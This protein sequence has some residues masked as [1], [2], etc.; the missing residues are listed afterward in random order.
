MTPIALEK[1]LAIVSCL[2]DFFEQQVARTPE[3]VAVIYEGRQ[4]SY[5][6]LNGRANQLARYLQGHGVGPEVLV[7]MYVERS[8]EMAVGLLGILKA[9]GAYVPLDPG[10]PSERLAFMLKDS[11]AP[12]LLTQWHL[13]AQ[14][15]AY[16]GRVVALDADWEAIARHSQQ[17]PDSGV[18]PEAL[19]YV[20]YT[21]GS[22]GLPKGVAIEH[23]SA[24]N[25]L[26]SMQREPGI[27]TRDRMLAV[28]TLSFDIAGLELYLPLA[29]GACVEVVSRE[30]AADPVRLR[31]R[32]EDS[33]ATVMQATPASWRMLVEAGWERAPALKVLC[34]GEALGHELAKALLARAREVWNL[35]GP[36]ETTIWSTAYKVE[37]EPGTGSAAPLGRPIA[38]TQLYVLDEAMQPVPAGI[39][40][41]LYIGGAGLAR[42]YVNRTELTAERFVP[43][44]FGSEPGGRLYRTGDL[45]RYRP[46]GTLEFLG[47]FDQQVKLR[48]FRV[49]LGE[50]EAVLRQHPLVGE[51]VVLAREDIPGDKRLVGYVAVDPYHPPTVSQLRRHLAA[52]LPDY[53][54][55][56]TFVLLDK[57]PLTPNGKV[58]RRALSAPAPSRPELEQAYV[59]PRTPLE[60]LLAH[61]W[62]EVLHLDGVGIHDNFFDLGGDSIKGAAFINKLQQRLEEPIF[63]VALF[64]APTVADF[65]TFLTTSYGEAVSRLLGPEAHTRNVPPQGAAAPV[66]ARGV[67][68]G[69]VEQ[70]RQL[71]VPLEPRTQ[72][73]EE[74][75]P[76][77]PRAIFILA[78]PRSGTTLLRVM[79]AGHPQLFAAAELQLLGFNTL[80]ERRAAFSGKYSLWLEG[81]IRA[82]MQIHG[83]DA[84]Q[85]K[86]I[87]A[88][89]EDQDITTKQFYRV[90]QGWIAPQTLVDKSPSYALDLA[91]LM[92]AESDFVE[93]LYIHL[94]RHPYS[95]V[96]SFERSRLE[97]VFFVPEHPFS[98]QE[99]GELVWLVSHQNIVEFLDGVP[100]ERQYRMHFE[101]LTRQPQAVMEQMCRQLG[102]EYHPDLIEP[103][104]DKEKKMTDGIYAAS[105]PMGDTKFNEYQGIDSKIAESWKEVVLDNFLG[106]VTWEWAERLGYERVGHEAYLTTLGDR[107]EGIL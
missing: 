18:G 48:G 21:S 2:H 85:A 28:T 89:Y 65:A 16:R 81:T 90:L 104:K 3:A 91:T 7:G 50:I 98:A 17:A 53:M 107:E 29:V 77:N 96:R 83:C 75:Q 97:Q 102:L 94:V 12:V 80:K 61:L 49:E 99:L 73:E 56:S 19:A 46:D 79:L 47:R 103:Y 23:R 11:Q 55:P 32:M 101:D 58:D 34:G 105:A 62:C 64:D 8:L 14:L 82:V 63:I 5:A 22:T 74:Q 31:Q 66:R 24:V 67:D 27:G 52:R 9:G 59:A 35:Y 84:D 86:H 51:T 10:F 76:K 40:G 1:D 78:P 41:E 92:R 72:S 54:V 6:E 20:I 30:V 37:G 45:A 69:M 33:G 4:L 60:Q 87:L 15:P 100:Q 71:I 36:T 39:A 70:L 26:A 57:L 25:F 106:E 68:A 43:D 95:M 93:A 38:N 44:P 42:G 13:R 88:R